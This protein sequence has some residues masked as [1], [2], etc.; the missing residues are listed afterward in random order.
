[1]DCRETCG[2]HCKNGE[3]CDYVSG[4]CRRGCMDGYIG[5]R[6]KIGKMRKA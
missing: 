4:E 1:M 5:Q 3:A 6:C 2:G